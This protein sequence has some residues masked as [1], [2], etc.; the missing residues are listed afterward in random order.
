MELEKSWPPQ[1]VGKMESSTETIVTV[2][3]IFLRN[4]NWPKHRKSMTFCHRM[5]KRLIWYYILHDRE[6][7]NPIQNSLENFFLLTIQLNALV[8]NASNHKTLQK[9]LFHFFHLYIYK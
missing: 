8:L 3:E 1:H 2:M 9:Y 7:E 5:K 4:E 6:K